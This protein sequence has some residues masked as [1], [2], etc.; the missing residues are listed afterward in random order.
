MPPLE[1]LPLPCSGSLKAQAMRPLLPLSEA[2]EEAASL[3][4]KQANSQLA[5]LCDAST[6]KPRQQRPHTASL[7][8]S[9]CRSGLSNGRTSCQGKICSHVATIPQPR[10]GVTAVACSHQPPVMRTQ[11]AML[12]RLPGSSHALAWPVCST[13]A[14]AVG[15]IHA[16]GDDQ[17]CH[18]AHHDGSNHAHTSARCL[19]AE[20]CTQLLPCKGRCRATRTSLQKAPHSLESITRPA[21]TVS[22]FLHRPNAVRAACS[23][24]NLTTSI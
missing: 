7:C 17:G 8:T 16:Q 9:S 18:C 24:S 20:T 10:Q 3:Q 13:S 12:Q 1:A 14:A 5:K 23:S 21:A 4:A 22:P 2:R 11:Q 6:L 19:Q 15:H